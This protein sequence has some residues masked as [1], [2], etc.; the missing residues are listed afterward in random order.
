MNLKYELIKIERDE[1]REARECADGLMP[2]DFAQ[3]DSWCVE[4]LMPF[5]FAQGDSWWVE[6]LI[7]EAMNFLLY[8]LYEL[9]TWWT[10]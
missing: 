2:F 6:G 3:G 10:W 4:G 8:E 1:G 7:I 5:D 9:S